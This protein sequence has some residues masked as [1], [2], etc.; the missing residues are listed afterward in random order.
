MNRRNFLK[1]TALGIGASVLTPSVTFC[2]SEVSPY[3]QFDWIPLPSSM[4]FRIET[5]QGRRSCVRMPVIAKSTL[6]KIITHCNVDDLTKQTLTEEVACN[7][8]IDHLGNHT[9]NTRRTYYTNKLLLA[10]AKKEGLTHIYNFQSYLDKQGDSEFR[11]YIVRGV[12]KPGY[13]T[14]NNMLKTV[15]VDEVGRDILI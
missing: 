11:W 5:Y 7:H 15:E 13:K 3:K 12:K 4:L 2:A 10:E 14:L 6:L 8:I 1:T 9:T